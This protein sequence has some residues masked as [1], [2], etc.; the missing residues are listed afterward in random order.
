MNRSSNP[1]S[2]QSPATAKPPS[3][4]DSNQ[5]LTEDRLTQENERFADT[6]AVSA[7]NAHL[8]YQPAFRDSITGRIELA[9]FDDGRL[10]PL[11]LLTALPD[12]WVTERDADGQISAVH[13]HIVAG[14]VRNDVFFTREQLAPEDSPH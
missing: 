5:D 10:A 13:S 1:P 9:R 3:T 6:A 7:N 8:N 2:P 11:H 12:E 4:S 14:F